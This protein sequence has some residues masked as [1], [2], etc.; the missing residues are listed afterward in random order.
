M[1]DQARRTKDA[2]QI[3]REH[4]W[5]NYFTGIPCVAGHMA[6]RQTTNGQCVECRREQRRLA[7]QTAQLPTADQVRRKF[8]YDSATGV[9]IH[10]A[11]GAT[12]GSRR[13]DGRI[14]LTIGGKSFAAHRIAW[15]YETGNWPLAEIDHLDGDPGNNRFANLR[16]VDRKTNMQNQ[17]SAHS[18]NALGVLGVH[19]END[20]FMAQIS[21]NGRPKRIGYF[22]TLEEAHNAYLDMKRRVHPGN[23]L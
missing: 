23:L 16:D 20:R 18:D 3:A 8:H 9:F 21:I 2:R 6:K 13:A 14:A 22:D 15:L 5:Q 11:S 4:G 1:Q 10:R 7:R 17:R 19:R 12:A